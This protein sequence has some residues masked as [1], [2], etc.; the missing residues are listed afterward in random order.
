MCKS[1]KVMNRRASLFRARL[2]VRTLWHEMKYLQDFFVSNFIVPSRPPRCS[3]RLFIEDRMSILD[4]SYPYK[5]GPPR[6]PPIDAL[7]GD[8]L[9]RGRPEPEALNAACKLGARC[10]KLAPNGS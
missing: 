7:P 10:S 1:P 5:R 3:E 8:P 4:I 2:E 6:H 9:Q